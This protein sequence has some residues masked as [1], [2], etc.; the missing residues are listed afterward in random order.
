M[1]YLHLKQADVSYLLIFHRIDVCLWQAVVKRSPRPWFNMLGRR[2]SPPC[3][4][5][6]WAGK[7]RCEEQA[8][9]HSG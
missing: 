1:P 8:Q 7:T 5:W 6:A 2:W 3:P 9:H 4:S